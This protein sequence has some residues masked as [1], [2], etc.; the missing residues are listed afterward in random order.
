MR[1]MRIGLARRS[2][3]LVLL[4]ALA[5]PAAGQKMKMAT[6]SRRRLSWDTILEKMGAAWTR[7]P[8]DGSR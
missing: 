7:A 5:V 8:P 4:A 2:L 3:F 1:S 6:P